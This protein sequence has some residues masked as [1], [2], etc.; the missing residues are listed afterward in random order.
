LPAL[1]VAASGPL[2][3][4]PFF[5][6]IDMRV[7]LHR[8]TGVAAAA[9]LVASASAAQ[10]QGKGHGKEHKRTAVE[11]R[12]DDRHSDDRHR[13]DHHV[14]QNRDGDDRHA[15]RSHDSDDRHVY[16]SGDHVYRNGDY[17]GRY[18]RGRK[19]VPPGLAKKPGQMPPG[20]YKKL[21]STHQGAS[22]LSDVLGRRGYPVMRYGDAG[23]SRYVYYRDHDGRIRRAIVS[24]GTDRLRFSNVP[25]SLLSEVISRLY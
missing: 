13:D 20:Q 3:H 17:D 24:P 11:S 4:P 25:S 16:R 10:A 6:E 23:D 9:L 1:A 14:S 2:R 5:Q 12:A 7:P 19:G 15:D 18:D 8:L 22:V 21:Y